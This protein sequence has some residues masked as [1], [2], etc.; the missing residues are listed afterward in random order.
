MSLLLS[1][2]EAHLVRIAL[3]QSSAAEVSKLSTANVVV[4]NWG[5]VTQTHLGC[6]KEC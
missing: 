3:Q 5:A 4:H 2:A 6:V 1:A